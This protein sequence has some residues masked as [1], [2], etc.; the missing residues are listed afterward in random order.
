MFFGAAPRAWVDIKL[1]ELL[2]AAGFGR[3]KPIAPQAVYIAPPEDHRKARF[4]SLQARVI[5]QGE[6]FAPDAELEA[7]VAEMKKVNA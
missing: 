1:R 7:F 3:S 4:R 6:T 5:R 2:K